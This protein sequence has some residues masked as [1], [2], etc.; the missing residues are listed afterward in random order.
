M[1]VAGASFGSARDRSILG[2]DIHLVVAVIPKKLSSGGE[3]LLKGR[4]FTDH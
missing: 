3:V 4:R 1:G 2:C